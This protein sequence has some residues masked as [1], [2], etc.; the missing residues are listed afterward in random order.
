[1]SDSADSDSPRP[2]AGRVALVTGANSGIGLAV[3]VALMK[4]GMNVGAL[5]LK[6]DGIPDGCDI[7]E[8]D[9]RNGEEVHAAIEAFG[10]RQGH[11][12]LLVNNAG[13]SFAGTIE[14]GNEADWQ[15]V[16]DV[17]VFGQMRTVRAALPWLRKST[18][19][20]IVI[21]SSCS[22][23]NGIPNRALYS[24]SKGAV[25]ALALALATD[26][27]T[28]RIRVNC[29][30]PGTVDTPFM[31]AL[32]EADADPEA[33]RC[34]YTSRQPTGEMIDPEEVARAVL[35]LADPANRSVTGTTLE[36][37]GGMKT[38]RLPT[39]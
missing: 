2:L 39:S 17:N 35:Y 30:S 25:Q 3:A 15:R 38:L 9:L 16:F 6:T 8:T 14:D 26:L 11:L 5:D 23:R 29:V 34:E 19:A 13:V 22:A 20:S 18:A 28:E 21:M 1:M 33:R 31:K 37:D 12:D 10:Q 32:I 36:I 24:A 7:L 27:V 4:A